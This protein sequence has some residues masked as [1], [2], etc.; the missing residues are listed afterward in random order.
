MGALNPSMR[1]QLIQQKGSG[2]FLWLDYLE[3]GIKDG[4]EG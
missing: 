4:Q 2:I 1:C 3:G